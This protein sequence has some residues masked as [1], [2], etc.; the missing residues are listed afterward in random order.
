MKLNKCINAIIHSNLLNMTEYYLKNLTT[1][2]KEFQ[3]Y[4]IH[5]WSLIILI[6][7]L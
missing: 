1:P 6:D 2:Y 3:H 5:Q 4:I 7:H